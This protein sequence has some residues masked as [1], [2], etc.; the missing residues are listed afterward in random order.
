M[1]TIRDQAIERYEDR[2][3]TKGWTE[4]DF[5]QA[6][7]E[8]ATETI[9]LPSKQVDR[10]KRVCEDAKT[11]SLTE[12]AVTISNCQTRKD[13]EI[14]VCVAQREVDRLR[15]DLDVAKANLRRAEGA[16][17]KAVRKQEG[18]IKANDR[19]D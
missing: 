2:C 1:G 7:N 19:N 14:T 6:Q 9:P 16:I 10:P 12:Q 11:I 18:S 17:R 3:F 5:R 8:S 4:D 15:S 13:M